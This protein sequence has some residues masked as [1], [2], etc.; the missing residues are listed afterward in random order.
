MSG[1]SL[2]S[3]IQEAFSRNR[4]HILF[5]L[6]SASK[7]G[8]SIPL[9]ALERAL[10][11]SPSERSDIGCRCPDPSESIEFPGNPPGKS[12]ELDCMST[13]VASVV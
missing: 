7:V 4:A 3:L 5:I 1:Y 10:V 12:H 6:L 9:G 8:V 13:S 2:L 11:L